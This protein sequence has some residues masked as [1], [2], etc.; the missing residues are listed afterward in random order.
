MNKIITCKKNHKFNE[1]GSESVTSSLYR[2]ATHGEAWTLVARAKGGQKLGHAGGHGLRKTQKRA[3][4][5][6]DG[7]TTKKTNPNEEMSAI[8]HFCLP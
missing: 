7:F 2:G 6:E 3:Q 5:E 1:L 8:L 4:E